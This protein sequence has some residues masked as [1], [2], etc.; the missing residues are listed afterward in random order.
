MSH[1][2]DDGY[3]SVALTGTVNKYERVTSAGAVAGA[4]EVGIG[5]AMS[6]GVSGDDIGVALYSKQG[7]FEAKADGAIAV[8]DDVYTA[9]SGKVTDSPA[10][11]AIRIGIA[12]TA[13]TADGDI[14]EVMPTGIG[15]AA[16]DGILNQAQQALSTT[17]TD[18]AANV[19]SYYTA[20]TSTGA[21]TVTLADGTFQGQL[22]L[23]RLIVDGG[24]VTF[25]PATFANGTSLAL[26]DAGDEALLRWDSTDGWQAVY[27]GNAVDG[28]SAPAVS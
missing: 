8:D 7:T 12:R 1:H 6:Y 15:A 18:D 9:A 11:G 4:T 27:L 16:Q 21:H 10:D 24:T 5:F 20:I 19:T 3:G 23:I 26:A 14:I 22:K 2:L 17:G 13:A 28:V 25:T